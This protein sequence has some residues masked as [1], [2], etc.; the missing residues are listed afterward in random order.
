[1]SSI[2]PIP[3][4]VVGALLILAGYTLVLAVWRPQVH[5]GQHQ[6]QDN[7]IIAQRYIYGSSES[8]VVVV[9]SSLSTRLSDLPQDYF[10]LAFGS[11]DSIT[12]LSIVLRGVHSPQFVLIET[13]VLRGLNQAFVSKL[14]D[15]VW[16]PLRRYVLPLRDEYHPL[17]VLTSLW[18]RTPSTNRAMGVGTQPK[19]PRE[20]LQ[21]AIDNAGLPLDQGF[22][23]PLRQNLDLL[24]RLVQA[25]TSKNGVPVFYRMPIHPE[26]SAAARTQYERSAFLERFPPSRY[27]WLPDAPSGQFQTSDGLHLPRPEA[28]EYSR[29]FVAEVESIRSQ[30][31]QASRR[32]LSSPHLPAIRTESK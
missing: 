31:R 32:P 9:G 14:Y 7:V 23:G 18:R 20:I 21:I 19:V 5:R 2:K 1:M 3:R 29:R 4:I 17:N 28:V 8:P 25:V 10:N 11:L 26:V 15:P 6:W 22:R 27:H 24:E 12:G 13:N 16:Y 30:I